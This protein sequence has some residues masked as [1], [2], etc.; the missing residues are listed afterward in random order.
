[1]LPRTALALL[2]L[3]AL[4][5]SACTAGSQTVRPDGE[6]T[7]AQQLDEE[8]QGLIAQTQSL[9]QQ[10]DELV[11]KSWIEGAPPDFARFADEER[12]LYT[13]EN[14][15]RIDAATKRTDDPLDRRALEVLRAH[16]AGE[17]LAAQ[18][19]PQTHALARREADARVQV[20]EQEYPLR[21]LE[22]VLA[23]ERN[24]LRRKELSQAAAQVVPAL[25]PLIAARR[26]RTL[27]VLGELGY[28]GYLAFSAQLRRTD[29]TRLTQAAERILTTTE[30][31]YQRVVEQ[32]SARELRMPR[33]LVRAR[34]LPRMFRSRDVDDLF[35]KE[36]L[37]AR[38]DATLAGLGLSLAT[39]PGLSVD[40]RDLPQKAPLPL[41]LAIRVPEDVR[42]S[43]KPLPGLKV[44]SAFLHEVG[45]AL[46][47]TMTREQRYPL[48]QLGAGAVGKAWSSL[49]GLL[50]Q[51]PR[52]LADYVS[53]EGDRQQRYLAAS[54]AW[55]LYLLR[56]RAGQVLYEHGV[57]TG[58][59][60]P[61]ALYAQVMSRALGVPFEEADAA[62][63]LRA[64]E[65]FFASAAELEA[66]LL[67]HQL[68]ARLSQQFGAAW[69]T[70]AETAAWLRRLWAHGHALRASEL[71]E[72]SGA[73][74]L[75]PDAAVEAITRALGAA[76]SPGND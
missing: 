68:Q 43:V 30:D 26:E 56:R 67:A 71:A 54:A 33:E 53:L 76:P 28:P 21:E 37:R 36:A 27:E 58:A 74:E 42:L 75:S 50:V 38:V 35:P 63:Y 18:I 23:R 52:W 57:H 62:G 8:V 9:R 24:A 4:A 20:G 51:D 15:H 13:L 2:A 44:H 41:A 31:A 5:L 61:Q 49:F 46:H 7:A 10:Q 11:W 73:G 32:L 40:D 60:D 70:S 12:A 45:H 6:G 16:F 17:Y 29:L 65:E 47:A 64:Q 34:D 25:S 72:L 39:L 59:A 3:A 14:I 69:W 66:T 48:A 55:D 22:R 1:M 19:A